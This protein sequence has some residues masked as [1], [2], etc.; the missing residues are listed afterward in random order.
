MP[1]HACT[2]SLNGFGFHSCWFLKLFIQSCKISELL[3]ILKKSFL[4]L[5]FAGLLEGTSFL[6][7]LFDYSPKQVTWV[8]QD[9]PFFCAHPH[10]KFQ[11]N[12]I[13]PQ[14]LQEGFMFS[15]IQDFYMFYTHQEYVSKTD[16]GNGIMKYWHQSFEPEFLKSMV[17]DHIHQN[18]L[19]HW[20]ICKFLV[21]TK[22]SSPRRRTLESAFLTSLSKDS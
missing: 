7:I 16:A 10:L 12:I 8:R 18:P 17:T 21:P 1:E 14:E 2:V 6:L 15:W 9:K 13:Q 4:L 11:S 20:L 22:N 5:L 3:E 19:G